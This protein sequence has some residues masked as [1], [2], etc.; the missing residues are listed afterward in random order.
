MNSDSKPS[1]ATEALRV[2]LVDDCPTFLAAARRHLAFQ[3]WARVVGT[4][5]SAAE[6]IQLVEQL[7]P[8]VVLMDIMMP[9]MNGIEATRQL[10]RLNG[11][12][13]VVILTLHDNA[14]Y[15]YHARLAGADGFVAKSEF[16]SAL[17]LLIEKFFSTLRI[18][19]GY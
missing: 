9:D 19:T 4:A 5:G 6:A 1:Q 10:K 15:R 18:K 7:K 16:E 14:E 3:P 11:A 13:R 17:P 12:P 8:D 2:L